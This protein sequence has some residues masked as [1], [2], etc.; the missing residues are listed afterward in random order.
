MKLILS[1]LFFVLSFSLQAQISRIEQRNHFYRIYNE[2]GREVK[3]VEPSLVRVKS[4]LE[5]K[6]I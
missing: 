5:W 2:Q 4:Y 1:L 6:S 3:V